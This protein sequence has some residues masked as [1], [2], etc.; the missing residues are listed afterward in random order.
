MVRGGQLVS[1][2]KR[3][4]LSKSHTAAPAPRAFEPRGERKKGGHEQRQQHGARPPGNGKQV[5]GTVTIHPDGFGFVK[6]A[7]QDEDVFL[8][9]Q[10]AGKLVDGDRVRLEV[11][12]GRGGRTMGRVLGLVDRTRQMAVGVYSERNHDAVVDCEG[13]GQIRVPRTQLARPGDAVKVRLGAGARLLGPGE[14]L[15]GEVAGSIGKPGDRSVEVLAIAYKKGFHDEFPPEVMD[16]AD[17]FDV[18]VKAEEA[19][20]PGRRDLRGLPLV[21]IDGEDARDFDDAV[22]CEDTG[23][24]WRLVVAI[25]DVAQ[26]V[27]PGTALNAEALRRATSVYLPG[28]VLPM[29]P[30]RLSNGL[31]SLVPDQDRLC[32]VADMQIARDG[33]PRATTLYP[34]V[35]R[36]AARCTYNEVH[37]VLAGNGAANRVGLL[38]HFRRLAALALSLR[39]MRKA[40]G[41]I[42][43]DLLETRVELKDDGT[44]KEMVRRERLES[45]RIVEECMLAA[46]EAVARW[47]REQ[48]LPTVN[49]H[50]GEPDEDKVELFRG[51]AL[52]HG[53]EVPG[54][55]LSSKQLNKLLEQLEGHPEQRALNQLLLRSMMQAVYSSEREGH[56]GLGAPDYLHFTSPIRRY[57]DLLVHRLLKDYWKHG[58]S[59]RLDELR[60]ELEGMAQASSERERAAMSVERDVVGFYSALL[61]EHRVGEEFNG[62]IAGLSDKAA[63]VE[64]EGLFIEGQ[65]PADSLADSW[66]F[67]PERHRLVLGGSKRELRVGMPVRVKLIQVSPVRR[68]ILLQAISL[69]GHAVAQPIHPHGHQGGKEQQEFGPPARPVKFLE[70]LAQHRQ[71]G[72]G[73]G[74]G[75]GGRSG[76]GGGGGGAQKQKQGGGKQKQAQK[77]GRSQKHAANQK[78][79]DKRGGGGKRRRF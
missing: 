69:D 79:R 71:Q 43:F 45:H 12:P 16:E 33:S 18:H 10:E 74:G 42:D 34:G 49:R 66:E 75:G 76:G 25:A 31:C 77:P 20:E 7:G 51:L 59:H 64:L 44:P 22:Y 17:T 48:E 2:G 47:F 4:S 15:V 63:Y 62:T 53:L 14:S 70:R 60:E 11:V 21:T 38:P 56:Y 29:L 9:P 37:D 54:G 67:V 36:S 73:G 32:L 46:N 78:A 65:L 55:E 1:E 13:L 40:R 35:M 8:P 19:N 72:G 41:A 68:L 28:R 58:R 6:V 52:A 3:F 27:K 61:L 26:Y 5:T 57:P 30:E 23:D 50:H 39:S 24:G